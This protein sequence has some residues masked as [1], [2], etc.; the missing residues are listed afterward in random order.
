[1]SELRELGLESS[2][3]DVNA[4]AEAAAA[5]DKALRTALAVR[6]TASGPGRMVGA[7]AGRARRISR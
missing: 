2:R 4:E 1:V 3:R 6:P 7:L 5:V